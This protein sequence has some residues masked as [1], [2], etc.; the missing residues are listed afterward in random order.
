MKLTHAVLTV[1][2]GERLWRWWIAPSMPH[3]FQPHFGRTGGLGTTAK[4]ASVTGGCSFLRELME[5]RRRNN[6]D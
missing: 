6:G 5:K 3:E 4:A 2:D 1:I